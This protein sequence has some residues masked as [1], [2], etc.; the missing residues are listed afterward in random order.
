[1]GSSPSYS[2]T[3]FGER[4][5]Q[6]DANWLQSLVLATKDPCGILLRKNGSLGKLRY[7]RG[8]LLDSLSGVAL[9]EITEINYVEENVLK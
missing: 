1:M 5:T 9:E 4:L 7:K 3:V 2:V 8:L 6:V